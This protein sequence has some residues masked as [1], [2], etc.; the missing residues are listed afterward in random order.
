MYDK[1]NISKY[2]MWM[3][4]RNAYRKLKDFQLQ[5]LGFPV[6]E[7]WDAL[8]YLKEAILLESEGLPERKYRDIGAAVLINFVI[9]EFN[10]MR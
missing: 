2:L 3:F 8:T 6:P 9:N 5:G 1:E 4:V 7:M 10:L